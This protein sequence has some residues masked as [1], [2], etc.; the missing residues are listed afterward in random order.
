MDMDFK[1]G[2]MEHIMKA[3]GLIIKQMDKEHSGMQKEIFIVD[4]LRMIWQMVM[5]NT[6]I[7]TDQD[8]KENL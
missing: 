8:I 4:S 5:V 6:N 1:V 7:L 2:Q 3:F